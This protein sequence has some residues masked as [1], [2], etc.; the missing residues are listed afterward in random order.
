[1][2]AAAESSALRFRLSPQQRRLWLLQEGLPGAPWRVTARISIAGPLDADA[3]ERALAGVVARHEILRTHFAFV[4]TVRLPVQAVM[5]EDAPPLRRE[6]W[7]GS[8]EKEIARRSAEKM[9][10]AE[11]PPFAYEAGPLLDA[12]LARVGED[13]HLLFVSL[14][15]LCADEASLPVLVRDLAR[16][17]AHADAEEEPAVQYAD[18]A[19]VLNELLESAETATGRDV[20]SRRDAIAPAGPRL[21][22]LERPAGDGAFTP[23][24][25]SITLP[26]SIAARLLA[27]CEAHDLAPRDVL[28]AAWGTLLGRMSGQREITLGVAYDG[29]V[30]EGLDG[31]MGPFGR[32][33]PLGI[34]AHPARPF[35]AAGADAGAAAA[36][37][38]EWQ[39]YYWQDAAGA[40]SRPGFHA[41][42]FEWRER[43]APERSGEVVFALDDAAA[44]GDRFALRLCG[45][46][47]GG[48]VRLDFHYDEEI[49]TADEVGRVSARFALLLESALA[50]PEAPLGALDLLPDDERAAVAAALEGSPAPFEAECLHRAFERQAALS[51]DRPAVVLD[52]RVLTFAELDARANRLAHALRA[53]GVGL[54]SC[55][56]VLLERSPDLLVAILGVL[57]AGGAYVPLDPAY[58]VERLA[59]MAAGS[60]IRAVVTQDSLAGRLPGAFAVIRLDGDA[61]AERIEAHPPTPPAVT[62]SPA[63]LA[64]VIYTSGSTGRPKGVMVQHR[65]AAHL[66]RALGAAVYAGHNAPLRVAMNAPATFD[67]SVKQWIQ[68]LD[69]HTLQVIPEEDRLDPRRLATRLG[70]WG[71][72]VLDCT[73]TQLRALLAAG[74]GS[75]GLPAPKVLLVGGEVVD[76]ALWA[77][78]AALPDTEAYNVYGPTE[79]T[80]DAT[81]ARVDSATEPTLGRPLPNMGVRLL[82]EW[83]WPVPLGVAGEICIAGEGLARGYLGEAART[84]E[85]F[86]PDPLG[87]PGT[88]MYRTGDMARL[89]PGGR[90]E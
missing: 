30:Y 39:D 29:R 61:D 4:P 28:L 3:L 5:E 6:D 64:Y 84:A 27:L 82:D 72:D 40:P 77:R 71:V 35:L 50:T 43:P 31:A 56:G 11:R 67:A 63:N 90:L 52:E 74:L 60:A 79:A 25:L 54:E 33:L 47:R 78:L 22:A 8:G 7:S 49:L 66:A 46:R 45:V 13:R 59:Y 75:E 87:A 51:P 34:A 36:E 17:H 1:M 12:V 53:E 2:T 9:E 65:S 23:A 15:A 20:W 32:T 41:C 86:V 48:E 55:V 80:V 58:P 16:A 83:L 85:R 62:V 26:E 57:K 69:G 42:G 89:H 24:R 68:L 81:A 44:C 19:D 73:P 88:R 37:L 70:E 76:A 18:V 10:Q 21:A 38:N 14:P